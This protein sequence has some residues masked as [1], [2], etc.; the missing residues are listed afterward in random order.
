L[1]ACR[2]DVCN[3][4][5]KGSKIAKWYEQADGFYLPDSMS[6]EEGVQTVARRAILIDDKTD[7]FNGMSAHT[8]GIRVTPEDEANQQDFQR[9]T[10][11]RSVVAVYGMTEALG[12]LKAIR[13]R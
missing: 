9:G 13:A 5:D 12:A 4:R 8:V 1:T 2:I 3:R 6:V 10:L 11:P 7:S